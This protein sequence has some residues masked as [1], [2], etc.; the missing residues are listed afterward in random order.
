MLS[1]VALLSEHVE[2]KQSYDNGLIEIYVSSDIP[3]PWSLQLATNNQSW[4][5]EVTAYSRD[6]DVWVSKRENGVPK[7][8]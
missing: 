6:L 1:L 5:A 3:Y 2:Y 8:L 7:A 4:Y